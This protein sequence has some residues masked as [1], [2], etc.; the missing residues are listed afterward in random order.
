MFCEVKLLFFSVEFGGFVLISLSLSLSLSLPPSFSIFPHRDLRFIEVVENV[1]QRL[2]EYNLHKERTGS[3]RFA[4]VSACVCVFYPQILVLYFS[5]RSFGC[6]FFFL[7]FFGSLSQPLLLSF[8]WPVS[9][10]PCHISYGY[11]DS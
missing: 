6:A 9:W 5:F 1:C 4:K 11:S 8:T 7:G 10:F 3:N 2:L